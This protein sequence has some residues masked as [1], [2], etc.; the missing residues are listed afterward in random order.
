M[1]L[2]KWGKPLLV[3]TRISEIVQSPEL[4]HGGL[5]MVSACR[6]LTQRSPSDREVIAG[7]AQLAYGF[8]A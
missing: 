3:P 5:L 1:G 8:C 4:S 2:A 6:R 7:C